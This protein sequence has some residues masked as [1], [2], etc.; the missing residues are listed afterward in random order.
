IA[1]YDSNGVPVWAQA[2]GGAS[3][4]QAT[5][6]AVDLQRNVYVTGQFSSTNF[7]I[8]GVTLTNFAPNG[9]SSLFIAK[10]N[11]NGGLVWLRS[12]D[13]NTHAISN[14]FISV[15]GSANVFVT[16]NFSGTNGIAGT[17]LVSQGSTDILLA[18][19]DTNGNLLWIKQS[20][21]SGLDTAGSVALDKAGNAYLLGNTRSTDATFGSFTFSVQGTSGDQDVI[22]AKFNPSGTVLWAKQFGGTDIEN[23]RSIALDNTGNIFVTGDFYGTTFPIGTNTLVNSGIASALFIAKLDAAGN[24]LWANT[25]HGDYTD[26][27]MGVAVDF[28]G[29]SYIAGFFQSSKLIFNPTVTLTNSAQTS[30]ADADAYVAKY[31]A[32]G[33]LLWA[34]RSVGMND[35]R[36]YSIA[37]DSAANAYFTGWTQGTN[38]VFGTLSTTN[39]YVDLFVTK[40]D[41]DYPVLRI[42][43]ANTL[44]V[45]SWPANKSAFMPQVTSNFQSWTNLTGITITNGGRIFY[46]NTVADKAFFRLKKN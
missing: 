46:T 30:F 25:A 12:S 31:D 40:I 34:T 27:S 8:A 19:F 29:N 38:V 43:K 11:S 1:K 2:F 45:L 21:G 15:D 26:S 3:A 18:K 13:T 24:P 41:S 10:F 33:N 28:L 23:G 14:P 22:V 7:Q 32:T 36:A 20:G 5:G 35:Q 4:D 42:D 39:A 6:I 17:N 44:T 9:A 16:A 37:V